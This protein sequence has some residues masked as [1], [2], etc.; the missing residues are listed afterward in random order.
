MPTRSTQ[1]ILALVEAADP[2]SDAPE[3]LLDLVAE[4]IREAIQGTRHANLYLAKILAG[5]SPQRDLK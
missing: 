5:H 1:E 2:D 4:Q 3:D